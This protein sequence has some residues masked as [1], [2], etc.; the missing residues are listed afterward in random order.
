MF[1]I[2]LCMLA[3]S[4]VTERL[5]CLL[6]RRTFDERDFKYRNSKSA[7]QRGRGGRNAC[8]VMKYDERC[9]EESPQDKQSQVRY[10]LSDLKRPLT[11]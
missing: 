10:Q 3:Y 11:K 5:Q 1:T 2:M 8:R 6:A 9:N 4:D 7:V